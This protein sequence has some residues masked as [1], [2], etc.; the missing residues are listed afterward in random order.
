MKQQPPKKQFEKKVAPEDTLRLLAQVAPPTGLAERIE[1]RL[2][3]AR[4]IEAEPVRQRWWQVSFLTAFPRTAAASLIL[5]A[6][7]GGGIG[8]YQSHKSSTLPPPVR[9]SSGG[10]GAAG[11]IRVAPAGVV[12]PTGTSPRTAPKSFHGRAVIQ[13]GHK[14]RPKGVVVPNTPPPMEKKVNPTDEQ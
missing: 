9:F 7:I 6:V 10:M 1:T 11:A 2:S 4:L 13:A 5:C 3:S 8:L 12:P 14:T